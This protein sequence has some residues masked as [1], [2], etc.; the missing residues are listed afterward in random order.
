MIVL[1]PKSSQEA[2]HMKDVERDAIPIAGGTDLF[3][4]WPHKTKAQNSTYLDL[5]GIPDLHYI[6]LEDNYLAM[7][8]RATFWDCLKSQVIGSEFQILKDAAKQVGSI[9]VQTR[10]TWAGN[11]ANGSPAADGVAALMACDAR[12]VL[13]SVNGK[14]S[15]PLC[16]YYTGYKTS[17]AEPN[18]IIIEIHIPNVRYNYSRFVKVG[19]R[20]A[21]TITKT[22]MAVTVDDTKCRVV[23]ISMSP[24]VCRC[25]SIERV[26]QSDEEID[27]PADLYTAVSKDLNPIDDIRSTAHYRKTV[28]SAILYSM[29]NDIRKHLMEPQ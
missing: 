8:A 17:V 11:I 25:P 14:R 18:E 4:K 15:F 29:L 28:F 3:V 1:Q 23:A 2:F 13:A 21:L 9:Q 10:G 5:S 12:V 6:T 16:D 7:G 20:N 22:G 27:T 26:I 19:A 24:A